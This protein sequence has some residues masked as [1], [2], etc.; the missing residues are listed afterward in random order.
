MHSGSAAE[1]ASRGKAVMRAPRGFMHAQG[2]LC[3]VWFGPP[4]GPLLFGSALCEFLC[5]VRFLSMFSTHLKLIHFAKNE[6]TGRTR[7]APKK[8]VSEEAKIG[9]S[10]IPCTF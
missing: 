6:E 8:R 4:Q 10:S 9:C 7:G 3:K 2:F 5:K 1:T